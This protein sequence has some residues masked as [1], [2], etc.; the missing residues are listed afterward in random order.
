MSVM[1]NKFT[2]IL[3]MILTL[4]IFS[5]QQKEVDERRE[6]MLKLIEE[7]EAEVKMQMAESNQ[8]DIQ[9]ALETVEAYRNYIYHYKDDPRCMDYSFKL[10]RLYDGVL[11]DKPQAIIEYD[12]I[13]NNYPD[14]PDPGILIFFEGNAFHD[15]GDTTNA[16]AKLNYFITKYPDH[17]FADDAQGLIKIIRMDEEEFMEMFSAD[18]DSAA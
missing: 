1:K 2:F 5:C 15:L 4:G 10:A 13:Y 6:K 9:L 17:E 18:Q 12:R 7:K 16:I 11:N 8:P 14:Y 3:F